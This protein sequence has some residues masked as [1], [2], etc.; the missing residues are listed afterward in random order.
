MSSVRCIEVNIPL[1]PNP[2]R[3]KFKGTEP[4]PGNQ[5]QRIRCVL[6]GRNNTVA[7]SLTQILLEQTLDATAPQCLTIGE[8]FFN[9]VQKGVTID[10]RFG[11]EIIRAALG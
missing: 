4:K 11:N 5:N 7:S 2:N 10:N 1:H 6:I 8:I 3:P 9:F